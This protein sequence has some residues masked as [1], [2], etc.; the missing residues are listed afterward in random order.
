M[1]MPPRR[2]LINS[3][4]SVLLAVGVG[5][6]GYYGL[7]WYQ[8]PVYNE[9]DLAASTE[10]NLQIDLQRRGPNLQPDAEGLE[11]MRSQVRAEVEA[12]INRERETVE[13]R[14]G[15]GLI[16]LVVGLGHMVFS[17]MTQR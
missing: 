8:L 17:R 11:R 16:A 1:S 15:I 3:F 6:C 9:T 13:S 5:L 14:F 7:A 10:L 4:P 12:E 2:P